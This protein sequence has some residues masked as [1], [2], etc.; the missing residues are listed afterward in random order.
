MI[1]ASVEVKVEFHDVDP[2]QV[3]WHGNYPRF[4]EAARRAL[5]DK[6]G[7]GYD[8]MKA[9]GY[10]WPVVDLRLH[11]Q[12]PARLG[13]VLR[14]TARLKE[15]ENRIVMGFEVADAATGERLTKAECVQVAVA[16]KTGELE[17]V[18]PEVF[19]AKVRRALG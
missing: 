10:L 9:S 3:A 5:F 15:W 6:L 12:R 2:M 16:D 18:T 4:L 13:Q 14:V 7:Y 1:D 19:Q 17:F 8:E 11:Y